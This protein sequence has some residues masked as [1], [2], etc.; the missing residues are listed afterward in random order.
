MLQNSFEDCC[1]VIKSPPA[2]VPCF[3]SCTVACHS[4]DQRKDYDRTEQELQ[5]RDD[6]ILKSK[7]NSISIINSYLT[8]THI[9][10]AQ[11]KLSEL[12]EARLSSF[13][14][15]HR[16]SLTIE[17]AIVLPLFIFMMFILIFPLKVMEEE[18]RLQNTAEA[19]GKKLAAAEYVKAVGEELLKKDGDG[20]EG[21]DELINGAEEGLGLGVILAKAIELKSISNPYFGEETSVF[22]GDDAD[23][24]KAELKYDIKLPFTAYRI[25]NPTAS[26]VV[27]RR[28]WTG[29]DGGRGRSKYTLN[30]DTDEE[31][32]IVYLGKT[33]TVYHED[34]NCHYISNV[35]Q[36]TDA[37]HIGELRNESG[38][39][40]HA[41]PSC[42]P[43]KSGTVY[44]FENGTAYHSSEQCKAITS[45]ARAVKLSEVQGMRACSYCGKAHNKS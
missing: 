14:V 42:K 20:N 22:A 4:I 25:A 13:Q 17:A 1:D 16:A 3:L 38:G 43:G 44:Y 31:D 8:F 11:Q 45:Y 35:M 27:N 30:G 6:T 28:A 19:V 12:I 9:S 7:L 18:R 33:A 36:A 32:R 15:F 2:A 34:P 39:K 26:M 5:I 23:M 40:Y 24:F 41:C 10:H 21:L 37:S 29:S